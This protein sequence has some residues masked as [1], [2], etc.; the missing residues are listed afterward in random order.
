MKKGEESLWNLSD[1]TENIN[2][3]IIRVPEGRK[4]EKGAKSFFKK[5][6]TGKFPN[7]GR[8]MNIQTHEAQRTSNR[9]NIK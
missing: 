4:K 5:P 8:K 7:M 9:L 1:N 6:M 2:I 3:C